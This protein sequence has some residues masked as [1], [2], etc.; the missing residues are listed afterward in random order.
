MLHWCGALTAAGAETHVS[1]YLTAVNDGWT[2]GSPR[3]CPQIKGIN[4]QIHDAASHRVRP[5]FLTKMSTR[6]NIS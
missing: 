2:K 5:L 4:L 6:L 3:C 1:R